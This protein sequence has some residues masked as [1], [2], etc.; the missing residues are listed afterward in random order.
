MVVVTAPAPDRS[1]NRSEVRPC[2]SQGKPAILPPASGAGRHASVHAAPAS[3]VPDSRAAKPHLMV[4]LAVTY[5]LQLVFTTE[6][7]MIFG[8]FYGLD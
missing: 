3:L 7:C 5:H 8:G 4:P 1:V 2:A 6:L